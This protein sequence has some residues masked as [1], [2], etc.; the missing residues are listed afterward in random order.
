MCVFSF[1]GSFLHGYIYIPLLFVQS[2]VVFKILLMLEHFL[3]LWR[4][5]AAVFIRD[6]VYKDFKGD[7]F[8]LLQRPRNWCLDWVWY[9]H[10]WGCYFFQKYQVVACGVTRGNGKSHHDLSTLK[11]CLLT[12][13]GR[14]AF[15]KWNCQMGLLFFERTLLIGK[16]TAPRWVAIWGKGP[17]WGPFSVFGSSF[18]SQVPFSLLSAQECAKSQCS[19]ECGE[20]NWIH[21]PERPKGVK[22]VIKQAW[23][24]QSRAEGPQPRSRPGGPLDF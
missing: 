16:P 18:L 10:K 8:H 4:F 3:Q 23:R 19:P 5:V 21:F 9:L 22:D 20:H 13:Q 24:A 14:D 15:W 17:H 1:D 7:R 11:N 6:H 12:S 2:C